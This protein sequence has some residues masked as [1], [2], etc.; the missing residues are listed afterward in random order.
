[1]KARF[2]KM[3]KAREE[4]EQRRIEEQKL[5][6]MQFEQKE[7]DAALQKVSKVVS[8]AKE[9]KSGAPGHQGL[10]YIVIISSSE[11]RLRQKQ[12]L[13][14]VENSYYVRWSTYSTV[15]FFLS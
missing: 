15:L 11:L 5:L 6:R 14:K 10:I 3:A 2:E 9:A 7:I 4:E 8:S 1:M 12:V 13:V